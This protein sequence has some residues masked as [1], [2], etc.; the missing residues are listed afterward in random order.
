MKFPNSTL[1]TFAVLGFTSPALA[2]WKN[3]T[4]S[5]YTLK[6]SAYSSAIANLDKLLPN[7]KVSSIM[8]NLNHDTK[9]SSPNVKNLVSGTSYTWENSGS[10]DDMDTDK[11]YPQ[12][13]TTSADAYDKGVYEGF[14][15]HLVSWHSDHYEDGKRGARIT[16]VNRET[17]KYRHVLLAR[18]K[19]DDNFEAIKKLHAGG[20]MW[21]GNLLYVVDTTGGL[22]V[23][24]LNHIYTVDDSIDD[25]IGK[26]GDK[27]GAYGYKYVLPQVRTY[28]WQ[29]KGGVKDL[30][31]S[32]VSL[33]RTTKP[34]SLVVGEYSADRTDCRV[35]RWDLDYTNRLL[36]TSGD[37]ATASEAVQH[38]E[39]KVQ[40]ATSVDG[41]YFLTQSG[42]DL[43]TFTWKGGQK[44]VKDVFPAVPED[45]SF[46][47]GVGLWTLMEVPGKRHAFAVDV[48]KF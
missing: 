18:P 7:A 42:G 17:K 12:G 46:E 27:Y 36:K 25:K 37:V 48:G 14:K 43:V 26:V 9:S 23:F 31:F 24:D 4:K 19:G 2:A 33:D 10:F 39:S 11:W 20:I 13:I 34:D 22:R 29:K 35:V 6:Q 38:G 21:Y 28:A 45:L 47:K 5:D 15:V 8:G 41:K 32:F 40:G 16:F 44:I 30:R 3:L 1:V